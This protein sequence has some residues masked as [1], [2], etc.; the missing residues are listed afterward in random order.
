MSAVASGTYR[1]WKDGAAQDVEEP[2]TLAREGGALCLAGERRVNGATVLA[3]DAR[4]EGR[5]CTVMAVRWTGASPRYRHF[6][7]H[8]SR[9]QW[10]DD[11]SL[12]WR[13]TVLPP[14]TLL[15]PLLR[16]ASGPILQALLGK[17]HTVVLP[18]LRDPAAPGFLEPELSARYA[19]RFAESEHG[20]H[21]RYFG[22]EYGEA[23]ADYWLAADGL[24][25][26]Y[27]WASAQG[28]WEVRLE[29][30]ERS[31]PAFAE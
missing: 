14:D 13:T 21:C 6:R 10:R 22:G 5:L 11:G 25:T 31:S 15:Y 12:A 27:R 3:V 16:A 28:L 29:D 8:D 4:Y 23:G 2:W 18:S 30:S 20:V 24:V 17:P 9:V 7:L 19:Q 26:R 1:Y